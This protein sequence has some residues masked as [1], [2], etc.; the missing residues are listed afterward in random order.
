MKL[1][2]EILKIVSIL[3]ISVIIILFSAS[4]L[5]QN[6]VTGIILKS[7]NSNFATKLDAGSTRLS[8]LRKFPK[9]SFELK[10]VL[11]HSSPDFDKNLFT[12]INTDTLLYA[13][14]AWLDFRMT[15][16]LKGE[17]TFERITIKSG[18]LN[19]Y[20]D[21]GA[22]YNYNVSKPRDKNSPAGKF[23]LNL[24]RINLSDVDVFYYDLN[25][26]LTVKGNIK[27]GK[28]KSRITEKEIDFEGTSDVM[29]ELF[30]L[31]DFSIRQP[32]AARVDVGVN[33]NPKGYFFRKSTMRIENWDFILNGYVGSDNYIDLIVTSSNIDISRTRN[34]IP[35]KYS[36][37]ASEFRPAGNLSLVYKVKGISSRSVDP[38]YNLTVSLKNGHIAR[39]RSG[40]NIDRLSF[41]GYYSNGSKNSR[42]TS[43]I[44]ISNFK[45]KFGSANYKGSFS[46]TD[47]TRPSAVLDLKGPL[48]PAE[49]KEFFN[50]RN[51]ARTEGSIGID[52]NLSGPLEKKNKYT[53]SDIFGLNSRSEFS[54]NSFGI[55]LADKPVD[56]K[57]VSGKIIVAGSTSAREFRFN[58]N[59]QEIIMDC[60][61]QNLPEWLAGFPVSLNGTASIN[62]SSIK[63]ES[64]FGGSEAKAESSVKK[65]PLVLPDAVNL[66]VSFKIGSFIYKKFSAEKINGN[67]S[68]KPKIVNV[69]SLSLSSQEG[70]VTGNGLVVQHA[71]K[72]FTGRGSFSVSGIDINKTFKSFS[73]FSQNFLKADN[74][75]GSLSGS[76]T[77]ILPVDSMLNPKMKS[78]TAEGKFVLI[79]GSLINFDP[80]KALSRFIEL[81][82]LE[83]IKF[84]KLEN[85]F[86]IR[87]NHF[88]LPQM[89]IKSSAV[90]M[91]VN[92]EHSF[93][94]EYQYHVK[95]L[96]S[97]LLSNKARKN[98]NLSSEFGEVQDDG[99]GRTSV[100]LKITGKGEDVKVSYDMKAAGEQVKNNI[101]KEKQTLKTILN[102]EYGWYTRDTAPVAKKAPKKRFRVKWEGSDS[103]SAET[104]ASRPKKENFIDKI[105]KKKY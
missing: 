91:S 62:A 27:N 22:R 57:S 13:K 35:A 79:K 5:M 8:L 90:D 36:E 96:L 82:E 75:A 78:L 11:V 37:F 2:Y 45:S 68:L 67:L 42:A 80:V 73:N 86:F 41:D 19:L 66:E 95:M 102:E 51:I 87:D 39:V 99:L 50:L 43:S 49:L 38:N 69:R 29:Y 92:G 54:F 83:N 20:T 9:A 98:S 1:F 25:V 34:Y 97:E 21:T 24:N 56:L 100:L 61:L 31:K 88:Y 10:N 32:V 104:E 53:L 85:D 65:A 28:F 70:K 48:Y 58:L 44:T 52:I 84:D 93:D 17:Y 46:I 40:L 33:R 15:D 14:S 12:G 16:L 6:K 76:L 59:G 81:S 105:L 72:S 89:D 47:F 23:S 101:K 55:K 74:L 71:D 94:N 4:V 63:P 26:R 77:L 18:R 30:R 60:D 3:I 64:F 103:T 7:L